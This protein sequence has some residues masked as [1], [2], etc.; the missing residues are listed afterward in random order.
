[1]KEGLMHMLVRFATIQDKP[2]WVKLAGTVAELFNSPNMAEDE[3]FHLYM[4]SKINKS[5]A[6]AAID[7]MSGTCL[8]MIGFSRTNHRISWFAVQPDQRGKGIGKRLL[9]TALRQIDQTKD[10]TVITFTAD[11]EGGQAARTVYQKAGFIDTGVFEDE[12][13][14]KRCTMKRIALT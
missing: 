7:T 4:D 9:D 12:Q 6:L 13:G 1:M 10:V 8:G 3:T 11:H 2:E 14:N 5:E